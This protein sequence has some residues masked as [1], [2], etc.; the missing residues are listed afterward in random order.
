MFELTKVEY[1]AMMKLELAPITILLG[2]SC[3]R[4]DKDLNLAN[5]FIQLQGTDS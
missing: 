3:K 1:E 5:G 4:P 2:D